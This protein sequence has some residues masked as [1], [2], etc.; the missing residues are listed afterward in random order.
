MLQGMFEATAVPIILS[1]ANAALFAA[2][3]TWHVA[4]TEYYITGNT[5]F[6]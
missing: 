5:R 6:L 3:I 2:L 4:D 1:S